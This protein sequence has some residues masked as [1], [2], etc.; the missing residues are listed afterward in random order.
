[1][2]KHFLILMLLALLPLAGWAAIASDVSVKFYQVQKEVGDPDPTI[3]TLPNT[4]YVVT[5]AEW[6]EIDD[7]LTFKR[8]NT[9]ENAGSYSYYVEVSPDFATNNPTVTLHLDTSS[10]TLVIKKKEITDPAI[11]MTWSI[12]GSD[13]VYDGTVKQP[14]LT[15]KNGD[16]PLTSDDYDFEWAETTY[17]FTK[18]GTYTA[19]I[20][21]KG[22]NYQGTTTKDFVIAPKALAQSDLTIAD[23]PAKPYQVNQWKP[24]LNIM[25]GDI[26]LEAGPTKDYTVS[27][28]NNSNP[29][30]AA[31]ATIT[32]KNNYANDGTI[33]K[34]FTITKYNLSNDADYA[35]KVVVTGYENLVYNGSAQTPAI[36]VKLN[37]TTIGSAYCAISWSNNTNATTETSKVKLTITGNAPTFTGTKVIDVEIAR[38]PLAEDGGFVWTMNTDDVQYDAAAHYKDVTATFNAVNMVSPTDFTY[39]AANNINAGTADVI[40]T[41]QGNFVGTLVKHFTITPKPVYIQPLNASKIYGTQDPDYIKGTA[42]ATAANYKLGTLAGTVFT[43]D[44]EAE[45]NGKVKFARVA[46]EN[47]GTYKIYVV[48][49]TEGENDNYTIDPE[50]VVNQPETVSEKNLFGA[51]QINPTGQDLVLKFKEGTTATKVYGNANPGWTINDLEVDSGLVPGDD[52][53]DVK[54]SL[55]APVFAIKG[56]SVNTVDNEVTASGMYSANYPSV[57][58]NPMPF[59]VTPRTIAV[60][61]NLQEVAYGAALLSEYPTNWIFDLTKTEGNDWNGNKD[62]EEPDTLGLTLLTVAD[63]ASYAPGTTHNGVIT[64][65]INNPNYELLEANIT[66]GNMTVTQAVALALDARETYNFTKIKACQGKTLNVTMVLNRGNNGIHLSTKGD[67]NDG[68]R[69]G[70]WNVLILPFEISVAQLSQKLGYAI[71]NIADPTK[72]KINNGKANFG[73]KLEM[74]L[75]GATIAAHTPIMVKTSESIADDAIIDFGEQTIVAPTDAEN[76]VSSVSADNQGWGWTFCGTYVAEE[77]NNTKSDY[78][79]FVGNNEYETSNA[80]LGTSS[81]QKFNVVP[82]NGYV[83]APVPVTAHEVIFSFEE[84]DGT[85]TIMGVTANGQMVPVEGWYTLNGVKL[86]G[87]PTEKGIYINNGKKVVIK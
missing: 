76:P 21:G 84:L 81:T 15:V 70:Q 67:V 22:N 44:E 33:T 20:T 8:T 49:Y 56:D 3:A 1:M 19:N 11:T 77:I 36:T 68:W 60:K 87:I 13:A 47:V 42:D 65:T 6:Y 86:N 69:A 29:G 37:G 72:A 79:F 55:T 4:A 14:T 48:S 34:T 80:K 64:A 9:S 73:F 43:E 32:L 57:K 66:K 12:T 53:E 38:K 35:S 50:Q 41:G 63:Q 40:I 62:T 58:V 82:F 30:T 45:L 51:F 24:D 7:Y 16:V 83:V 46:G 74:G 31:T 61:V 28:S 39:V 71:V 27:Y 54:T 85:T 18:A 59:T 17:D 78:Q 26:Q 5:G 25:Y 10:A 75:N 2:R 23:I 52:W